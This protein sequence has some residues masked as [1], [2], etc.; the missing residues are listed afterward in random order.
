M[1]NTQLSFSIAYHPQTL[2]GDHVKAWDQKLCQA[3]FSHN[4]AVNRSTGFSPFQVVY[5]AQPRGLLDLVFLSAS[6]YVP[7]KHLLPYHVDSSDDDIV[8]NSRMHFVYPRGD[9]EAQL[10]IGG[11]MPGSRIKESKLTSFEFDVAIVSGLTPAPRSSTTSSIH[12]IQKLLVVV[13]PEQGEDNQ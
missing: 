2:V 4:H 7:K 1:V 11:H 6:G 3:E 8:V 12:L 13:G 10:D 9:D 5:S